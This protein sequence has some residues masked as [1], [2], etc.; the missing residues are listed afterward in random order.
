MNKLIPTMI[1]LAAAYIGGCAT[2]AQ[3][4]KM[5]QLRTAENEREAVCRIYE[6]TLFEKQKVRSSV[7]TSRAHTG[8]YTQQM[9]E[10]GIKY[11]DS[12]DPMIEL[13]KGE[14]DQLSDLV[15]QQRAGLF[16]PEPDT[17]GDAI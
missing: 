12:F 6:D 9:Y 5:N 16:N 13:R 7:I 1:I 17:E 4:G 2:T 8:G 10:E 15:Q 14:C 11:A 3:S